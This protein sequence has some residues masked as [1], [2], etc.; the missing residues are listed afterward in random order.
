MDWID[1]EVPLWQGSFE[2]A[3]VCLCYCWRH[4]GSFQS[5]VFQNVLGNERSKT[6]GLRRTYPPK[7]FT[8]NSINQTY[9]QQNK[10]V[11]TVQNCTIK[12]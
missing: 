1:L 6:I 11:N 12:R 5:Q 4:N 2:C 3:E 10:T 9:M 7:C 8:V